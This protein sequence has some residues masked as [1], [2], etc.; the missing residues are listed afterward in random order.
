MNAKVNGLRRPVKAQGSF[1]L[2]TPFTGCS[3]EQPRT[4]LL[5][6]NSHKI[7]LPMEANFVK[8][9]TPNPYPFPLNSPASLALSISFRGLLPLLL[10]CQRQKRFRSRQLC[11]GRL[12]CLHQL[13]LPH[14]QFPIPFLD[15]FGFRQRFLVLEWVQKD[16]QFRVTKHHPDTHLREPLL[17]AIRYRLPCATK[18]F[19]FSFLLDPPSR[20]GQKPRRPNLLHQDLHSHAYSQSAIILKSRTSTYVTTFF[21]GSF[22]CS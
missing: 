3:H 20:G 9:C 15:R 16:V 6:E 5:Y 1:W 8:G 13:F 14:L 22:P 4:K 7:Y 10:S 17:H 19:R 11:A 2:L 21:P 12:Y 18:L